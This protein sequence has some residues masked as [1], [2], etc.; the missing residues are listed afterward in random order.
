MTCFVTSCFSPGSNAE[1]TIS[2]FYDWL[3]KVFDEGGFPCRSKIKGARSHQL[4]NGCFHHLN[5]KE[6]LGFI[7]TVQ[8]KLVEWGA[9]CIIELR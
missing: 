8:V 3:H 1:E 9:A 4:V 5:G 2:N 6:A 7:N